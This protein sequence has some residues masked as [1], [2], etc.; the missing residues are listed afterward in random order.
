M[1][2]FEGKV[3]VEHELVANVVV[4]CS[5]IKGLKACKFLIDIGLFSFH[6]RHLQVTMQI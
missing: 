3:V 6:F 1:Y 2:L 5:T 4:L